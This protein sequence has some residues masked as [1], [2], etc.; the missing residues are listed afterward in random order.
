MTH[1]TTPL[2]KKVGHKY[3]PIAARW[4]VDSSDH[5]QATGTFCLTYVHK[6]GCRRYEY[7][8]TPATAPAVAAMLISRVAMEEKL[9]SMGRMS[10]IRTAKPYTKK[11]LA[12]IERFREEMGGMYPTHWIENSAH[13]ISEAAI[14]AVLEFAP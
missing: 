9:Y 12:A 5:Q 1:D 8:V 6:D 4:Y 11:Q 14:K 7:N 3:V 2:Y 13:E 10:P